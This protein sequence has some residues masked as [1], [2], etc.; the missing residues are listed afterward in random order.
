VPKVYVRDYLS[1]PAR[2]GPSSQ[3]AETAP[4]S[5]STVLSVR[6]ES[7]VYICCVECSYI[8]GIEVFL[9]RKRLDTQGRDFLNVER[10]TKKPTVPEGTGTHTTRIGVYSTF[11]L[12]L[13]YSSEILYIDLFEILLT[14][15]EA[16]MHRQLDIFVT[17]L[18]CTRSSR[19]ELICSRQ[20]P[21]GAQRC[22]TPPVQPRCR[23]PHQS[24]D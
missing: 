11:H 8:G 24:H 14:Q 18:R 6:G 19:N 21:A 17:L 5:T 1:V 3:A 15:T 23:P 16:N 12:R 20:A 9:I 13:L 7:G 2:N 10:T 22:R 4:V